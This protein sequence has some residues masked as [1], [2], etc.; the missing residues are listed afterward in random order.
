MTLF[1][2]ESK[3]FKIHA[4]VKVQIARIVQTP[5][6]GQALPCQSESPKGL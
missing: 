3:L 4:R 1:E 5:K 6:F 2:T